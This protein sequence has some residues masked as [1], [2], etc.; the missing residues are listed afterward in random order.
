MLKQLETLVKVEEES[1]AE[2]LQTPLVDLILSGEPETPL[3]DSILDAENEPEPEPEPQ[4][5]L[6]CRNCE[7]LGGSCRGRLA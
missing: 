6:K 4:F 3:V 2:A 1:P 7:F 5:A